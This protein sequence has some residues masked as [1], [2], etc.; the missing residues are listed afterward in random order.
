MT[1][2]RRFHLW[3]PW[4]RVNQIISIPI[5]SREMEEIKHTIL[6]KVRRRLAAEG[7]CCMREKGDT[8]RFDRVLALWIGVQRSI[9]LKGAHETKSEGCTPWNCADKSVRDAWEALTHPKNVLALESLYYQLPEGPQMEMA[10][11]ALLACRQRRDAGQAK[12]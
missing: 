2:R 1:R 12:A 5:V 9:H 4:R 10:R 7:G 6:V 11:K 8:Q 3:P